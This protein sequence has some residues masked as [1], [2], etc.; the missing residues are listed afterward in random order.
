MPPSFSSVFIK[1]FVKTQEKCGSEKSQPDSM[2]VHGEDV[3]EIC[4][5]FAR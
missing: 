5:Q 4:V 3:I 2:P 1:K